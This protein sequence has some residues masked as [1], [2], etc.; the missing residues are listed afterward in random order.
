MSKKEMLA[1]I[2]FVVGMA[3]VIAYT[4]NYEKTLQ[5]R[6]WTLEDDACIILLDHSESPH[7]RLD[8][9]MK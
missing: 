1:S 2:I 5:D 8:D 4:F 3:I 7:R 6:G 9:C